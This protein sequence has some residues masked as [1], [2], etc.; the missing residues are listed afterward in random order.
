MNMKSAP[1]TLYYSEIETRFGTVLL[2]A[3]DEGLA[4]CYFVGQKYM[5][6]QTPYWRHEPQHPV[7]QNAARQLQ[8]YADGTLRKFDLPLAF[9]H[10]TEFQQRV[11]RCLAAIPYG[12]TITY[13]EVARRMG[14]PSSVRA[15][16]AAIG[17]NPISVIVPCHRVL[18]S[19]GSLT[20]YAGGLDRK[21]VL[22]DLEQGKSQLRQSVRP[23]LFSQ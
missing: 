17:R 2:V 22:L 11:W 14:S 3:R 10:G 5:P 16:A 19:D 7:L 1:I 21:R 9:A 6:I 23:D 4:G 8:A 18:G 20:G 13:A 12:E 15:V